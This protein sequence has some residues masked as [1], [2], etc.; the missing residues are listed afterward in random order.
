M[1]V[2]K[3]RQMAVWIIWVLIFP[4]GIMEVYNA[5]PP[6]REFM[7]VNGLTFLLLLFLVAAFPII[8]NNTPI[9][10]QQG[11]SL[12]VFLEYGLFAEVILTQLALG[13]LFIKIRLGKNEMLRIPINSLMFFFIS[14]SGGL[15]YYAV[16]G[17]IDPAQIMTKENIWAIL[18][19][20]LT[21]FIMNQVILHIIDVIVF[22]EKRP[23]LSKDMLWDGISSIIVFPVGFALYILYQKISIVAILFIGFPLVSIAI[24]MQAYYSSVTVN[25]HLHRTSEIGHQLAA[26][27]NPHAVLDLFV[28]EVCRLFPDASMYV[29]DVK[30]GERLEMLRSVDSAGLDQDGAIRPELEELAYKSWRSGKSLLFN[31]KKGW[32]NSVAAVGDDNKAESLLYIPIIRKGKIEGILLL[33]GTKKRLF[34]EL[35][36]NILEILCSYMAISIENAKHYQETKRKSEKCLLTGAYNHGYVKEMLR[37]KHQMIRNGTL[38]ELSLLMIDLDFFKKINDTY[39]HESGDHVLCEATKRMQL[40]CPKDGIVARYGGEEFMVVLPGVNEIEAFNIGEKIRKEIAGSPIM[41]KDNLVPGGNDISL[42]VTA[43]IG[44]A[45]CSKESTDYMDIVR[46]ADNAMYMGAK[47]AGRNKVGV[48]RDIRLLE[49]EE[50]QPV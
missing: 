29:L 1:G 48:Y 12:A 3:Y 24:A 42:Y 7:N 15:A 40:H 10:L 22:K 25:K 32:K 27:L 43:S 9:F 45:S 18:A 5:F 8:I 6:N 44:V 17:S 39:G 28:K 14:L 47:K 26:S 46:N 19:Y 49:K 11:V 2:G 33:A 35:H 16:G 38:Q 13:A 4:Y 34:E 50:G 36:L 20:A 41:L 21:C 31:D 23:L 37:R 30:K